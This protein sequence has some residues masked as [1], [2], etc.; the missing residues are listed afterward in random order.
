[1]FLCD[2]LA[3]HNDL[4]TF[5][6]AWNFILITVLTQVISWLGVHPHH[7]FAMYWGLLWGDVA[8]LDAKWSLR[9]NNL[10]KSWLQRGSFNNIIWGLSGGKTLIASILLCHKALCIGSNGHVF[11][12]CLLITSLDT[13]DEVIQRWLHT[14]SCLVIQKWWLPSKFK[15]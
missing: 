4:A 6:L 15:V 12:E 2:V 10:L 11:N 3:I 13:T 7:Q 5:F 9:L 14:A 8:H 1:M